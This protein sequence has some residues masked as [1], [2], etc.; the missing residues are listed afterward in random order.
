MGQGV[1]RLCVDKWQYWVAT[2]DGAEAAMFEDLIKQGYNPLDALSKL[3]GI[4]V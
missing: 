4:P 2:S 3:S 1:G